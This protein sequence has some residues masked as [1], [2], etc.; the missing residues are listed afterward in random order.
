MRRWQGAGKNGVDL[1]G[2]GRVVQ[3][4]VVPATE[5]APWDD[6][7]DEATISPRVVGSGSTSVEATTPRQGRIRGGARGPLE[8]R[9]MGTVR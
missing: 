6:G 5:D 4:T 3:G 2:G 7:A 9:G 8:L 1:E